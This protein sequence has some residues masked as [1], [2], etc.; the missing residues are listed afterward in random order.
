MPQSD[1]LAKLN[2]IAIQ[3]LKLLT[4]DSKV[5]QLEAGNK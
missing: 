2:K 3:Q 1:R 4:D 5:K